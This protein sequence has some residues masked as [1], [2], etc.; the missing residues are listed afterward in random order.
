[1]AKK[2]EAAGRRIK[3]VGDSDVRIIEAGSDWGGR[4]ADPIKAD[5][6]WDWSNN[7][8]TYVD[9]SDAALAL[10]LEDDE[11][12]DVTDADTIPVSAVAARR[13]AIQTPEDDSTEYVDLNKL[14]QSGQGALNPSGTADGPGSLSTGDASTMPTGAP[15]TTTSS[16]Q[17]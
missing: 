3:Y 7:H 16:D 5:L 13:R 9:V 12:V 6:T 14:N 10:L 11:F 4:L 15:A 8:L 17:G 2:A 1:M